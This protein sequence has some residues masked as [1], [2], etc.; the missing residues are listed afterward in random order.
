MN[1]SAMRLFVRSLILE[2]KE[3]KEANKEPKKLAPKKPKKINGNLIE[4]KKSLA[5]AK[6][7]LAKIDE[8]I[9]DWEQVKSAAN[10]ISYEGV[11]IEIGSDEKEKIVADCNKEIEKLKKEKENIQKEANSLEESTLSEISKIKEM[12]GLTPAAGQEKMVGE[13]KK[14]APKKDK[15]LD[16][17][18]V[19][20]KYTYV[21]TRKYTDNSII[22]VLGVYPDPK[23]NWTKEKIEKIPNGKSNKFEIKFYNSKEEAEKALKPIVQKLKNNND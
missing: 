16:E 21:Q 4:M 19:E 6:E 5:E 8:L 18:K 2:E 15:K 14:S 9:S 17:E 13:T 10:S 3:K 23:G 11:D 12:I 22:N 7:K 1:Q 20:Q